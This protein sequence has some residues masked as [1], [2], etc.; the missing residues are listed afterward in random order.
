MS[1]DN[2]GPAE[3]QDVQ[4]VAP[5]QAATTTTAPEQAAPAEGQEGQPRGQLT[6]EEYEKRYDALK[7]DFKRTRQTER[8]FRKELTA[9]KQQLQPAAETPGF[10]D[11]AIP[12]VDDDPRGTIEALTKLAGQL[13]AERKQGFERTKQQT[14]HQQ[15]VST[16]T[17]AMSDAEQE[18]AF[19]NP[20]YY[21]AAAYFREQ[22][23]EELKDLGYQGAVL[24]AMLKRDL[25]DLVNRSLNNRADPA[26]AIYQRAMRMGFKSRKADQD[27]DRIER[28]RQSAPEMPR[29]GG[30]SNGVSTASLLKA[31][32]KDFD[33]AWAEYE[34]KHAG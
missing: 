1:Q 11:I 16:V 9:L 25:L 7:A 28:G 32:G 17:T 12:S 29:G 31:D 15:F 4:T 34:K 22:K 19:D 33:K 26:R 10:E 20:D 6:P 18:F 5:E 8:E 23:A 27:L 3:G 30:R 2:A 13:V 21:D 14:E 24:D